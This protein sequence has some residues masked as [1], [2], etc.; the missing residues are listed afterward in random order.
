MPTLFAGFAVAADA[1]AATDAAA[2]S[3]AAPVVNA[4]KAPTYDA[5]ISVPL[6]T[7]QVIQLFPEGVP[8]WKDIGPETVSGT[9]YTNISDPR[10]FVHLSLIHI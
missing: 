2:A 6:K 7:G 8:G 4:N 9:T 3:A 10:M 5:A 1:P